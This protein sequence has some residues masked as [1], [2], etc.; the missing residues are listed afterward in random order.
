MNSS[1]M[2]I[3]DILIPA[4][5]EEEALPLLLKEI[6]RE[7]IRRIVVVNN[8]SKDSTPQV[9]RNHGCEVIDEPT[10]GYGGACLAGIAHI[11]K[12]PPHILV[13]LDGDRSDHPKFLPALIKPIWEDQV[14]LVIGSRTLGKAERGS[15]TI[16]Q[17]FGNWLATSLIRLFWGRKFTD[18]GPFRAITWSSLMAMN[19]EDRTFGWTVEMQIKAAL[20]KLKSTEVAVDYR[21]RIGVSK[22]SGTLSGV[23]RA[24]TKILFTVFK[25]K[26]W[27]PARNHLLSKATKESS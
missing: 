3:I 26:F 16:T 25:Y 17:V 22:I 14:Q 11:A 15:L 5:D 21:C 6:D 1:S 7:L 20:L 2:P 18:L 24:G 19:M 13:F 27:P 10:P 23:F 8:A 4:R 9:A 12:N